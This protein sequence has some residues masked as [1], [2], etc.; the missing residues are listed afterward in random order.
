[1]SILF[2]PFQIGNMQIRNRFVNSATFEAMCTEDGKATEDLIKRYANLSKGEVGLIITGHMYVH[3][4]GQAHRR[5]CGIYSDEMVPGLK[6]MADAVH[7]YGGKIALQLAHAGRQSPKALIGRAPLAP[8]GHGLDPVS[9]NK[10]KQISEDQIEETIDAFV[11]AAKKVR[12]GWCRCG[13]DSCSSR[14]PDQ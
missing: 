3:P 8:S 7:Q 12:C 13:S 6:K 5:Q 10:P 2:E 11:S 4:R 9:L 1:M 14:I